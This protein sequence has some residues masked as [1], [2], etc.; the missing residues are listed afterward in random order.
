MVFNLV[1]D[2]LEVVQSN[3]QVEIRCQTLGEA[4]LLAFVQRFTSHDFSDIV[5]MT[6]EDHCVGPE[7]GHLSLG[8]EFC[9]SGKD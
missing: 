6:L 3:V 1:V 9:C 7:S 2:N 4:V 8:N 5:F